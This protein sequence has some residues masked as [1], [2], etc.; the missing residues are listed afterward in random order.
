MTERRLRSRPHLESAALATY[1]FDFRDGDELIVDEEG[2]E[3]VGIDAAQ[4]EAARSLGGIAWDA[5]RSDGAQ[6]QE[7]SIEVRDEYG[8]VMEVKFAFLIKRTQ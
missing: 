6:A 3:L 2:M 8:P 4:N 5:M 7:M 1:Y